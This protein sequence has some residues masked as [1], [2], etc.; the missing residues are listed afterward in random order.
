M[1]EMTK[2]NLKA[3]FAGESQAHMKYLAFSARAKKEG[4]PNI[5]RLFR[6]IAHAERVH[7][8]NHLKELGGI[9]DTAANLGAAIDG[10]TYTQATSDVPLISGGELLIYIKGPD[11]VQL[12]DIGTTVSLSVF[13][14]LS[15][16][17]T[18]CNVESA[19]S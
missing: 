14:G 3:A 10:E 16:Y 12:D 18:E 17:I 6:A 2:E 9:S 8:I 11:N 15:Q 4:K 13:T 19:T 1:K 5:A 7:A